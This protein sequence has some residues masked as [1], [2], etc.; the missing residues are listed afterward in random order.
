MRPQIIQH[1]NFFK[2]IF[3]YTKP[4]ARRRDDEKTF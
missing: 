2:Q 4:E 1:N 3:V